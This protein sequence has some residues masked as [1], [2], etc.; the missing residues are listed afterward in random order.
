MTTAY[1]KCRKFNIHTTA[2]NIETVACIPRCRIYVLANRLKGLQ[3]RHE[4]GSDEMW[5]RK[6]KWGG[7]GRESIEEEGPA[8]SLLSPLPFSLSPL[9][10]LDICLLEQVCLTLLYVRSP[11]SSYEKSS[12]NSNSSLD[13]AVSSQHHFFL[14]MKKWVELLFL[15]LFGAS[16]IVGK[17]S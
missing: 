14:K 11:R 1:G 13:A 4:I 9:F 3:R 5:E 6:S 2:Y 17:Y 15:L 7:R 16:A 10:K 12:S 8:C